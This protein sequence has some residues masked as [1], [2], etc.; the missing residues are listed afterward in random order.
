MAGKYSGK[1][2][3]LVIQF[4]ITQDSLIVDNGRCIRKPANDFGKDIGCMLQRPAL[5]GPG[6]RRCIEIHH[7]LL[8]FVGRLNLEFMNFPVGMTQAIRQQ[9]LQMIGQPL[10]GIGQKQIRAVGQVQSQGVGAF[11]EFKCHVETAGAG[12]QC[13]RLDHQI[14]CGRR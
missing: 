14:G 9:P 2:F 12:I 8:L 7:H 3:G 6:Q 5:N 4:P 10:H 13:N 11:D 1:H